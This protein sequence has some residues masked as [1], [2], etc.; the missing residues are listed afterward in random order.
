MTRSRD[1]CAVAAISLLL[2]AC[3]A[4][5]SADHSADHGAEHASTGTASH[6][7]ATH[8]PA[9]LDQEL[10]ARIIGDD[11]V[12]LTQLGL[13]RGHLFVGVRLYQE[14][15]HSEA[16]THMKHPESELYAELRPGLEQ[17]GA[18]DF[19][20]QLEALAVAVETH[21]TV[22]QVDR[23]YAEL[24]TSI[25]QAE[26]ATADIGGAQVAQVI[27]ALLDNVAYEYDIAVGAD[28]MLLNAHEYQDCLGFVEVANE[29]IDTLQ[30]RSDE[31]ASI[32]GLR[33]QMAFLQQVFPIT[34][35]SSR[36]P[37]TQPALVNEVIDRI[38]VTL[39]GF[40]L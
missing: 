35:P 8:E 17:R 3:G 4:D 37:L 15:E 2:G 19:A 16:A 10:V 32:Q 18:P 26:A 24:L 1:L 40:P 29:Y 36:Q 6:D 34:V 13:M 11:V 33:Q 5:H 39:A 38:G 22:A 27:K 20:S 14:G 28:G 7:M 23:L 30:Q 25:K 21:Q 31:A 12:Y 9:E